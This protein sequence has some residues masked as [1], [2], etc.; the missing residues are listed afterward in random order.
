MPILRSA[1]SCSASCK[2]PPMTTAIARAKTG[3]DNLGA[4]KS[5]QKMNERLSKTGVNAGTRNSRQVLRMPPA[6]AT[7]DINKI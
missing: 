4:I 3:C 6:K 7:S 2:T 5:V 1:G